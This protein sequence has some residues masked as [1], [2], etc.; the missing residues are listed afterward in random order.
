MSDRTPLNSVK[1]AIETELQDLFLD[2]LNGARNDITRYANGI[3]LD[4]VYAATIPD[5][6]DRDH[7]RRELVGQMKSLAET[8][9]IK[10]NEQVWKILERA[11]VVIISALVARIP[12]PAPQVT[13]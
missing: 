12:D 10:A 6:A 4:M 2:S 13:A 3:A 8:Q 5:Q 11:T 9:R 1:D 7:Y